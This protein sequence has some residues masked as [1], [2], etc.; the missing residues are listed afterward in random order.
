MP[1]ACRSILSHCRYRQTIIKH[2]IPRDPLRLA[3]KIEIPGRF[4]SRNS[5]VR[6]QGR[7]TTKNPST[8]KSLEHQAPHILRNASHA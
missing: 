7:Q 3:A 2:G 5:L 8:R 4:F 1:Q 6:F